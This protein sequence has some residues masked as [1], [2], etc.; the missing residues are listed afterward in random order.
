MVIFL[1]DLSKCSGCPRVKCKILEYFLETIGTDPYQLDERQLGRHLDA[2]ALRG[3]NLK[4][5]GVKS[6]DLA[7]DLGMRQD[8]ACHALRR[9]QD[10]KWIEEVG[11]F[12]GPQKLRNSQAKI[13]VNRHNVTRLYKLSHAAVDYANK[14]GSFLTGPICIRRRKEK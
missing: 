6:S 8:S 12:D 1:V 14:Y 10:T 2:P 5:Y 9:L 4:A 7:E 13:L 3:A 11:I